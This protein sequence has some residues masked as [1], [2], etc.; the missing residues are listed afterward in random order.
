QASRIVAEPTTLTGS[1]GVF[2]G[3]F[4]LGGALARFG[5][6]ARGLK[7]GGDYADALGMG[8]P[9]T[10]SQRA[11]FSAWM[12]GIYQGFV[13]RVARG[14]GLSPERVGDIARGRVWTGAQAKALGLVDAL[15]GFYQ[16]VD[17]ARAL[18]GIRGEVRLE[19]FNSRISPFEVLQSLFGAGADGARLI[20]T[21]A[22][23][24]DQPATRA[25]T[26]GLERTRLRADGATVLAPDLG[27]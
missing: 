8:A 13:D 11:A 7:V 14:R 27:Y 10:A 12:D 25:A 22:A 1:I 23:M 9:M 19:A 3:K 4:A 17:I 16:A 20:R 18:A 5:I 24:I 6:D 15:G 26:A 21:V 2:G